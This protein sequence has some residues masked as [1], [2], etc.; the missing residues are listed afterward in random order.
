MTMPSPDKKSS[1][2]D[3]VSVRPL[4]SA[5][6][7]VRRPFPGPSNADVSLRVAIDRAAYADLVAYAKESLDAEVCGVLVGQ[8]CEDGAGTFVHVEAL[9]RGNAATKGA[10]HVTFTQATWDAIH[11]SLERDHPKRRIVGWYHTHPGFGVEFSEMD[12][13]IQRNFFPGRTQI[14][15]VTDPMSGAVAILSNVE[16]GVACLP[17]YWVDGRELTGVVPPAA[18]AAASIAPNA[19]GGAASLP[20]DSIKSLEARV[21]QLIQANDE[22]RA[23]FHRIVLM[24][25]VCLCLGIITVVG[26]VVYKQYTSD[27]EPPRVNSFIPIPVKVGEKTVL[28]GVGVVEWQVPDE[29]NALMID[30]AERDRE[31]AAAEAALSAAKVGKTPVGKKA[32]SAPAALPPPPAAETSAQPPASSAHDAPPPSTSAEPSK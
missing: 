19:G 30:L 12:L 14:A 21:G 23:L 8:I 32:D 22:L 2:A 6:K 25:G 20:A 17:R 28:L 18:A 7:P 24:V 16:G 3:T 29:L 10:T 9:I 4:S 13:F 1:A 31:R 15:L 11:Q 26:Y 5:E 27:L